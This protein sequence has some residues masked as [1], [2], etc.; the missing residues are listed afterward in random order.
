MGSGNIIFVL[1]VVSCS[2]CYS[3]VLTIRLFVVYAMYVSCACN[4]TIAQSGLYVYMAGCDPSI[5]YN[6][7]AILLFF[8]LDFIMYHTIAVL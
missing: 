7:Y 3:T 1:V 8:I 5:I 6:I 2:S 4:N